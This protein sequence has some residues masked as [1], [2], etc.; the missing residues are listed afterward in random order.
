MIGLPIVWRLLTL[1]FVTSCLA[2][3]DWR[4]RR[5][6]LRFFA[7]SNASRRFRHGNVKYPPLFQFITM[8]SLLF[9]GRATQY[10]MKR[11]N[12]EVITFNFV[13]RA[14]KM[15]AASS[16]RAVRRQQRKHGKPYSSKRIK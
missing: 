14:M 16:Q 3:T 4:L 1:A 5:W 12:C 13:K 10:N 15:G 9:C 2:V 11:T 8:V 7:V 6:R